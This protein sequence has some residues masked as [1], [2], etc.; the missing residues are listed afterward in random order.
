MIEEN[1]TRP[2]ISM[3]AG[4]PSLGAWIPKS[5][6]V[7]ARVTASSNEDG[8]PLLQCEL[9]P[10]L[11]SIKDAASLLRVSERTIRR[12]LEKGDLKRCQ[13]GRSVKVQWDSLV[14]LAELPNRVTE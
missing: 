11:V 8:K 1:S 7:L 13:I 14:T 10:A 3:S 2:E 4:H 5:H 9:I 12:L 6:V